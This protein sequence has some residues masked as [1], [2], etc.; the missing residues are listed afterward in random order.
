MAATPRYA[1]SVAGVAAVTWLISLVLPHYHVANISMIYLLSVLA[2]AIYAGSGPAIVASFLSFLAFDWFFVPPVGHWNVSDPDEWL[3]LFLFL[4]VA[5][6]TGQLAAGLKRRAEEARQRAR[7][8]STLH[9]LSM[10]IL[11]DT[12]LDHVLQV[13]VERTLTTFALENVTVLLTGPSGRL[14]VAAQAGMP[15]QPAQQEERDLNA[16]WA[17]ASGMP[18]GRYVVS[19]AGTLT[20]PLLD[21]GA[22]HRPSDEHLMSAYLPII[23]GGQP[24][25]VV[26]ALCNRHRRLDEQARRLLGAFVAQTAL[27]V[28]RSKLAEEEEKARAAAASERFKSTFL[29]SVSHDLRTP[30]TAIK[31]AAEGLRQDAESRGDLAHRD[32]SIGIDQEADRLNRLVGNL[33]ELSRIEAGGLPLRKAHEDLSEIV[34]SVVDRLAPLLGGRT[35]T[36]RIPEDLPLISADVTQIDR[37]LENLIDNAAKFSPPGSEIVMEAQQL[38]GK[39][40]LRVKNAGH[41][42]SEAERTSVFERFVRG[43]PSRGAPRGTG[44]GLAICKGIV[45]AHGGRIWAEDDL[46]GVTIVF[47]LPIVDVLTP[48]LSQ[49][50]RERKRPSYLRQEQAH[51][52]PA[53]PDRRR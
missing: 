8:A 1:A 29:A 27:A 33:L 2:L 42:L 51:E 13:I 19:G 18:S 26:A 30:L 5:V 37:V 36:V 32:L 7:E 50:E 39:V 20:R 12:S 15:L 48:T 35:L 40:D 25:G 14:E 53:R 49:R 28:G 41:K 11:G 10:A 38:G 21:A 47:S 23:L 43:D 24:L 34:G 22:A 31:A 17:M 16:H 52:R 3:A 46:H 9:E 44:L 4:V 6:I 45:E